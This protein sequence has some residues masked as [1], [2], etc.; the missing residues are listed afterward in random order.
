MVTLPQPHG[1]TTTTHGYTTITLW[2]TGVC[3]KALMLTLL[4]LYYDYTS[5]TLDRM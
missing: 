4:L 1:Y 5:F 2:L 3:G